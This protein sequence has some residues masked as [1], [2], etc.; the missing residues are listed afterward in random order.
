[1]EKSRVIAQPELR[2]GT[3]PSEVRARLIPVAR[4]VFWWGDAEN[5][6]QDELRLAAQVM[7]F[8]NFDDVRLTLRLLGDKTFVDALKSAPAGVFDPKSWTFWHA[9]YRLP[10]PPLPARKL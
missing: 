4:R 8:G 9:Y 5:W 1:M 10:L 7:T 3:I 6:V 2:D